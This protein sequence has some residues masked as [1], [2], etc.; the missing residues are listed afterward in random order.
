MDQWDD[1]LRVSKSLTKRRKRF[2]VREIINTGEIYVSYRQLH[3]LLH[4][5]CDAGLVIKLEGRKGWACP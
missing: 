2:F 1:I 4:K 5:M 3:R